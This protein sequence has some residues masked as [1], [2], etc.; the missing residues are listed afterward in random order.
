MRTQTLNNDLPLYLFEIRKDSFFIILVQLFNDIKIDF[1]NHSNENLLFLLSLFFFVFFFFRIP[2][3]KL[4]CSVSPSNV[5]LKLVHWL[6]NYNN[7]KQCTSF[8]KKLFSFI[9]LCFNPSQ[10]QKCKHKLNKPIWVEI[11]LG[12]KKKHVNGF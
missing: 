10:N 4:I 5:S 2:K 11:S 12:L 8:L 9:L 6:N 3:P 1:I 7:K